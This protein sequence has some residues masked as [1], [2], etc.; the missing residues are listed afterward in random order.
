MAKCI[1]CAWFPWKLGADFSYLPV[2]RC[3]P[4]LKARRWPG[5]AALVEHECERYQPK[6]GIE[7]EQAGEQET[8]TVAELKEYIADV[9]D[10]A[11]L[12]AL[13]EGEL[14]GSARKTAI[15]TIKD[16]LEELKA[17]EADDANTGVEDRTE[18]TD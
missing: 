17:G 2:M 16:R 5:D 10:I 6:D 13:L 7:P 18:G 12:E 9:T 14:A 15:Q 3:H 11:T 4:E 8:M 1:G